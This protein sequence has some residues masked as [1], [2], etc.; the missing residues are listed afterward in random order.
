MGCGELPD[1]AV[2]GDQGSNTLVNTARAVGGLK[3]PTLGGLGLGNIVPIRGVDPAVP[4][5]ASFGR[6]AELS[7]G[8]DSTTGHWEIAGLVVEKAFP[9]FP[10][11]FPPGL[12]DRFLQATGCRW[13]LGNRTASGTA[14]MQDLGDE[15][16]RTGFPIVYTSADSVFQIAA[17]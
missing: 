6:M 7:K 8:K 1:A 12:M 14:I 13:F 2:Y 9:T 16:V 10:S 5:R 3:L 4:A 17:H 11:G 15:H